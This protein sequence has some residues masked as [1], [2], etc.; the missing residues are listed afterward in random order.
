LSKVIVDLI[1]SSLFRFQDL[2]LVFQC[3]LSFPTMV[4]LQLEIK[5]LLV[6]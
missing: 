4:K 5:V 1:D 2:D 6:K 3:R